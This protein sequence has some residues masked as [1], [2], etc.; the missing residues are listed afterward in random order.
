MYEILFDLPPR[1]KILAPPLLSPPQIL[2]S[3]KPHAP[4]PSE[5]GGP[6]MD[7]NPEARPKQL[8]NVLDYEDAK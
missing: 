8:E 6:L 7:V 2:G 1:T 5:N 4:A 3:R